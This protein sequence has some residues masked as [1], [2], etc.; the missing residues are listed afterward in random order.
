MKVYVAAPR[1]L[2]REIQDDG[3]HAHRRDH[4]P[5]NRSV[6]GALRGFWTHRPG[7]PA[8]VF[9]LEVP[10]DVPVEPIWDGGYH[11]KATFLPG[12]LFDKTVKFTFPQ[13]SPS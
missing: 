2:L 4:V 1:R 3:Y 6:K 13:R 10:P 8:V 5:A 9:V 7:M 11:L 12:R